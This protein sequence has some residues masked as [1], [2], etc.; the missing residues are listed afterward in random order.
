MGTIRRR[1]ALVSLLVGLAAA[2]V[3]AQ[4]VAAVDR[5]LD[6]LAFKG[7]IGFEPTQFVVG[8]Q[9]AGGKLLD[10]FRVI[11]NAHLGFGD[12]SSLDGG[13]DF[14][15]RFTSGQGELGFYAGAGPSFGVAWDSGESDTFFAAS[16]VGGVV[17]PV[18][19][20][21]GTSLELRWMVGDDVAPEF[22]LLAVINP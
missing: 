7:G 6:G 13:V 16:L 15:A 14:L 4:D 20:T 2:P 8:A 17:L 22:R 21:W 12:Y 19:K 11:P 10:I 1:L 3:A 18:H 9:Y 5:T